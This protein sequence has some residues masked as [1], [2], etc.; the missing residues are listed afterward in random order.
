ML[1][2]LTEAALDIGAAVIWWT[3]KNLFKGG[4]W[5]AKR[6]VLPEM[7]K[8]IEEWQAKNEY[9]NDYLF[10][11]ANV[12]EFQDFDIESG[13]KISAEMYNMS[14]VTMQDMNKGQITNFRERMN[15]DKDNPSNW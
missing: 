9:G 5:G 13:N 15:N 3:V 12:S 11:E 6:G 4:M 8:L 1:F 2:T 14:L 10:F 7:N